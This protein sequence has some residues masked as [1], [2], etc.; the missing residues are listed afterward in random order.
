MVNPLFYVSNNILPTKKRH[1]QLNPMQ[2]SYKLFLV[3]LNYDIILV[4]NNS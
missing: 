4:I 2:T 3:S 1:R